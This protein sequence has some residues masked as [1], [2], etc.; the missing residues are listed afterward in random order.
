MRKPSPQS[1]FSIGVIPAQVPDM[2]VKESPDDFN[3]PPLH[4]PSLS[5]FSAEAL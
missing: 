3:P 1:Q 2:W 4:H 5:V